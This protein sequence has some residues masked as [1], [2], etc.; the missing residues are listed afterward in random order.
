MHKQIDPTVWFLALLV[1]FSTFSVAQ[2]HV[3]AKIEA[4][5]PEAARVAAENF[6]SA[7]DILGAVRL[8]DYLAENF[9]SVGNGVFT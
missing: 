6:W 2:G 8:A 7:V 9:L 3:P 1:S 5:E 4:R